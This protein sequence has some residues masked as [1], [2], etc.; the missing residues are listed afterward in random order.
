MK[1]RN[2]MP[3][4]KRRVI[5]SKEYWQEL[6]AEW[7]KVADTKITVGE[8]CETHNVNRSTFSTHLRKHEDKQDAEFAKMKEVQARQHAGL[9]T[10]VEDR[11]ET[12]NRREDL[13]HPTLQQARCNVTVGNRT[14]RSHAT[15][16]QPDA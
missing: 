9:F 16:I 15:G 14:T 13:H 8:F 2:T 10:E 5:H 4:R 6:F 1:E 3:R 11:P 12:T 7:Y